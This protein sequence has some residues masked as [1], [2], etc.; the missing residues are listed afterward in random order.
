[1]KQQRVS[2]PNRSFE[3]ITNR[4][5]NSIGIHR[6]STQSVSHSTRS[7]VLTIKKQTVHD[8]S[9]SELHNTNPRTSNQ[10]GMNSSTILDFRELSSLDF[11]QSRK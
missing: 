2:T 1:M 8:Y 3:A 11:L 10:N 9:I 5:I 7:P 6:K 4:V